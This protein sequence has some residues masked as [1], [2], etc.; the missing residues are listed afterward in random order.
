MQTHT[1]FT[2]PISILSVSVRNFMAFGEYLFR[3]RKAKG[4]TQ[5]ELAV[6]V[7]VN[8][9]YISNL[10][11]DFSANTKS[12]KP[13]PSEDLC[14]R[15]ARVLE[16]NL[17]EVRELAGYAPSASDA[18]R[19]DIDEN[20]RVSMLHGKKLSIAERERFQTAFRA[21]YETAKRMNDDAA[22]D[23]VSEEIN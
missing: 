8:V 12:G 14:K 23:M 19:L 4:L 16:V 5:Q 7:G 13:R 21:A 15:I 22:P 11:R 2:S 3:W 1:P 20:V 6:A 18:I 9:S 17:D 10:E